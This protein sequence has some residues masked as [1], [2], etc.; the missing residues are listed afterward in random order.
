V[1]NAEQFVELV[2]MHFKGM[3]IPLLGQEG[4]FADTKLS[5]YEEFQSSPY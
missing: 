5:L 4:S 2:Q 3:E 1:E